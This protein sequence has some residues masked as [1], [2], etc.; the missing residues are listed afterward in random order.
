MMGSKEVPLFIDASLMPVRRCIPRKITDVVT[1][2]AEYLSKIK[3]APTEV[4]AFPTE[5]AAGRPKT[6]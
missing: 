5:S 6:I 1:A 2:Y 3:K 4:D